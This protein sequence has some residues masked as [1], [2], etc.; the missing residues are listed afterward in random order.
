MSDLLQCPICR[1][2][3]WHTENGLA[4]HVWHAHTDSKICMGHGKSSRKYGDPAAKRCSGA[5]MAVCALRIA[6]QLRTTCL[7]TAINHYN[8]EFDTKVSSLV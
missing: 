7:K 8:A 4:A 1:E 5:V 3:L 2:K 6:R